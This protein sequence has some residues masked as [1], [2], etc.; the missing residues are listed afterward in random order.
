MNKKYLIKFIIGLSILLIFLYRLGFQNIVNI[1]RQTNLIIYSIVFFCLI[2]IEIL[3]S[4]NYSILIKSI[5][6]QIPF[7]IIFRLHTLSQSIGKMTPGKIGELSIL[8]FF[9]NYGITYKESIAILIIDKII[10]LLIL[11]LSA[12]IGSIFLFNSFYLLLFLFLFFFFLI[13][14]Y[15][16][17]KPHLTQQKLFS[18][19]F[20]LISLIVR[21]IK[22]NIKNISINF[23][24]TITKWFIYFGAVYLLF[25]GYDTHVVFHKIAFTV[26]ITKIITFIPISPGGLGIEEVSASYLINL[27]ASANMIITANVFLLLRFLTIIIAI[28][29]YIINFS[30]LDNTK[31]QRNVWQN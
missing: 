2:F 30:L 12:T 21:I 13:A 1:L 10:S 19:F 31:Q 28:I 22:S 29:M 15:I 7:I 17:F 3:A 11:L 9:N 4:L 24:L 20:I 27:V 6:K 14:L 8:K 23:L 26:A 18:K 25:I 5:N 16:V